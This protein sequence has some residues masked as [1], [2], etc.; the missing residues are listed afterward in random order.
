MSIFRKA[1]ASN[2]L[3]NIPTPSSYAPCP[4]PFPSPGCA[5]ASAFAP[6]ALIEGMWKVKDHY[7]LNRLSLVAAEAALEDIDA[8]RTNAARVCA[9]AYAPVC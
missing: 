9:D 3:R 2:S 8:M 1:A 7:N 5:L 4:S 6:V